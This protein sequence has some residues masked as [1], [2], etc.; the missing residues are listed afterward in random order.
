MSMLATPKTADSTPQGDEADELLGRVYEPPG[1][2]LLR[3]I[4][5]H[6]LAICAFAVVFAALGAGYGL[7]R[8]VQYTAGATLQV[9][10]VNPNSPGFFSYVQ[11]SASLAT[12]FSRAIDAEPVLAT[13]QHSLGI[14]PAKASTQ[15]SAAPVP[16]SPAFRI[17][18]TGGSAARAMSLANVAA[19]AV[20]A[21]EGESNSANPAAAALLHEY[22]DASL[23]LQHVVA[24]V[25]RQE[26]AENSKHVS[27]S[28]FTIA[29]APAKSEREAA[30]VRLKA[31]GAAYTAAIAS[32]APRRGLVSLIAG[33]TSATS[34]RHA[35]VEL[36]AL[37][38]LLAGIL[39]GCLAAVLLEQHRRSPTGLETVVDGHPAG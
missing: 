31:I 17:F 2:M 21:Y 16:S 11:S 3:A 28:A 13:V 38:G 22:Q 35:K 18:A 27:G 24:K 29:L 12:A 34:N 26:R 20:I 33:A 19:N 7:S 32:Q 15:L 9:G 36:V 6:K 23:A 25:A 4:G 1:G 39:I 8:P 37:V 10:Q 30:Q 5:R 14:A